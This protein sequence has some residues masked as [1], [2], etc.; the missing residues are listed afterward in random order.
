MKGR[1]LMGMCLGAAFAGLLAW[2]V[3]PHLADRGDSPRPAQ[4]SAPARR[5]ADTRP[6]SSAHGMVASTAW[7]SVP[8][9]AAARSSAGAVVSASSPRET[10]E[11]DDDWPYLSPTWDGGVLVVGAC[12]GD[13]ECP[14]KHA[15]LVNGKTHLR[16][17][18]PEECEEDAHC[19]EGYVC[20][21]ANTGSTGKRIRRCLPAGRR[22]EGELCFPLQHARGNACAE[23][24]DC[25][26]GRCGR[27]CNLEHPSCPVGYQCA[28]DSA[29][30]PASCVPSCEDGSCGAG[31]VCDSLFAPLRM[32]VEPLG[33]DCAANGCP[34]G[35][36][37][38]R[39][40]KIRSNGAPQVLSQ[41]RTPCGA[42][43][44]TC[45]EDFVCTDTTG[46]FCARRCDP[47]S[48]TSTCAE[49]ERCTPLDEGYTA[50]ACER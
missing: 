43:A 30:G 24:L 48:E 11:E 15:C 49:N 12:H 37:C 18:L 47:R 16:E 40:L 26:Y 38:D 32:C 3:N 13:A 6:L 46:G 33:E 21:Y 10:P 31:Q 17:C 27:P 7:W 41:C 1:I 8:S 44:G 20:R 14:P 19:F 9:E 23:G 35:Q 28:R 45:A 39:R 34:P 5:H 4:A 25:N 2:S 36:A 50:W 29:V 22:A 42:D